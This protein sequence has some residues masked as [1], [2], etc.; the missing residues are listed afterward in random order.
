M[1]KLLFG[2]SHD[3][4][5]CKGQII[6]RL[7]G[8]S[9]TFDVQHSRDLCDSLKRLD[10]KSL[11]CE[12]TWFSHRARKQF[13][14]MSIL[15]CSNAQLFRDPTI[16]LFDPH[17]D[18]YLIILEILMCAF[19]SQLRLLASSTPS[20]PPVHLRQPTKV[21]QYDFSS[22]SARS[23]CSAASADELKILE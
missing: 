8:A 15:R 20:P 7:T 22:W 21:Q 14:L 5:D 12:K 2:C 23:A 4:I 16:A 18:G 10:K 13:N 17:S 11:K 9:L 1:F 6:S 19:F 3:S